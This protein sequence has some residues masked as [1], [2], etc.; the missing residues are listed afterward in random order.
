MRHTFLMF[1]TF[2]S[3]FSSLCAFLHRYPISI[4]HLYLF[5]H[6]RIYSDGWQIYRITPEHHQ[7][8]FSSYHFT[9]AT[10]LHKFYALLFFLGYSP[11]PL[12]YNITLSRILGH[13]VCIYLKFSPWTH[14]GNNR[15]EFQH[16]KFI[17]G[18]LLVLFS[19]SNYPVSQR[20]RIHM[21]ITP[22]YL[23]S[24]NR[25]DVAAVETVEVHQM[26]LEL[27]MLWLKLCKFQQNHHSQPPKRQ[28]KIWNEKPPEWNIFCTLTLFIRTLTC[29]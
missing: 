13:R 25:Q 1:P 28:N 27:D 29:C 22:I 21:N 14:S 17:V 5:F 6:Y 20:V 11:E 12:F 7:F 10:S 24:P 18:F 15:I 26:V 8:Y 9:Y 3:L 16:S 19:C 4:L 2:L 23:N